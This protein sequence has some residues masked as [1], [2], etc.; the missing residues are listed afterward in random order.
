MSDSY[1]WAAYTL[2]WVVLLVFTRVTV[3]RMRR[4]ETAARAAKGER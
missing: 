2:T 3:R 4:A 1:I